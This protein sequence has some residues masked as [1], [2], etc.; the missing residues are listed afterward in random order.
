MKFKVIDSSNQVEAQIEAFASIAIPIAQ[1][2]ENF[3]SANN[4]FAED[5]LAGQFAVSSFL[6]TSERMKFGFLGRY[7]TVGMQLRQ[8]QITGIA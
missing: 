6:L 4:M 3:Q 7:L 2:M 8:T 5:A 1:D